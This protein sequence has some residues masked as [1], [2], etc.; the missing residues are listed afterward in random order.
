MITETADDGQTP[1]DPDE[2]TG[3]IPAW[4]ATRGNLNV[5]EEE[6]IREGQAWM[7][8]MVGRRDVPT[9]E[10]LRE[11]HK[12][13]FGNVWRWAGMYRTPEKNL[14]V[15]PS[16]ITAQLKNLFDDA[17]AWDEYRTYPL[18]ERGA[19]DGVL[20]R[21]VPGR[22]SARN[23][24]LATTANAGGIHNLVVTPGE[25]DYPALLRELGTGLVVTDLMGQGVNTV[26]GDNSR[27]ASGYW[28]ENG[29]LDY[30]VEKITVATNLRQIFNDIVAV[31]RD[32]GPRSHIL[33][34]T[35]LVGRMAVAGG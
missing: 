17:C 3:L 8:R 29:K 20:V 12:L 1:L 18:D 30:P 28:V 2:A 15:A 31:A 13:L 26:T 11:L 25:T 9:Q 16:A 14:G 27:G 35:I 32:M 21:Y 34:G 5:A 23:L 24:G 4:I 19:R 7:Q 6:N 33:T 10:F 22:L